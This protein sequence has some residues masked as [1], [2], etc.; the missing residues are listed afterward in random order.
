[1]KLVIM[2]EGGFGA[3]HLGGTLLR[4]KTAVQG[5]NQAVIKGMRRFE[6]L[7]CSKCPI[8]R[9]VAYLLCDPLSPP[10]QQVVHPQPLIGWGFFWLKIDLGFC[11]H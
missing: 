3:A 5:N 2:R 4:V 7:H 8:L 11:E 6:L 1:M 10:P 9:S